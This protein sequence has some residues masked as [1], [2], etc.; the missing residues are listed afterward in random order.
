MS[1]QTV[2]VIALVAV[3]GLA[4]I[5][6]LG[7]LAPASEPAPVVTEEPVP[8]PE[9][10]QPRD[11]SAPTVATPA[12]SGNTPPPT[13][14]PPATLPPPP[15][16]PTTATL[17]IDSDVAGAQVFIDN[18]F[19][20]TAPATV[21]DVAPGQRK[22]NVQAEGFDSV[23]EFFEITPGPRTITVSLRTIRLDQKVAVTH[24][25]RLG[26]CEGTLIATPAGLR[27]QTDN[28]N[29]GFT[30]ALTDLENFEVDYLQNNLKV[31][32]RGGRTYDFADPSGKADALYLFHQEVDKIRTRLIGGTP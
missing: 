32:I 12:P 30:A 9:P 29:D 27:Y 1:R 16:A 13:T 20:G 31:K 3:V 19:V 7:L 21:P 23:S 25:H 4:A 2:V 15:A 8:A 14:P 10:P 6:G 22:I 24:K 26:S 11:T 17:T 5:W 18:K 28:A